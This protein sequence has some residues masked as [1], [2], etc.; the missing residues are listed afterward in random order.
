MIT[1][2]RTTVLATALMATYAMEAR[3]GI[4]IT[5]TDP[6]SGE[7]PEDIE[8]SGDGTSLL[9][10]YFPAN[11]V[12]V[13]DSA[14]LQTSSGF[15]IIA[16]TGITTLENGD[17]L[18]ATAPWFQGVILSGSPDPA[19][20]SAQG[21][22]RIG[23]DGS[24]E[25]VATLPFE[26]VLPNGIAVD[27]RGNTY[28]SNLIGNEIYRIDGT[29]QA[30]VWLRDDILAGNSSQ[31][32]NTPSPGFALGGNG[33]Q[34]VDGRLIASNTDAGTLFS[35]PIDASGNPGVIETLFH[36]DEI[37]GIDGFEMASDGTVYGANLLSSELF[38]VSAAGDVTVLANFSDGIRAPAGV[39]FS[40][41]DSAL[42]FNNAS[43]PF[44]FIAPESAN[45]PGV[46]RLAIVPEPDGK[47]LLLGFVVLGM[48]VTRTR[49]GI[50]AP[51]SSRL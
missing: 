31:D 22:W 33:L 1:T 19:L 6:L 12:A 8:F 39:A 7:I 29:G 35:I 25:Q 15:D 21:V 24:T 45:Q 5:P 20:A 16:P 51:P 46:G 14:T 37:I 30:S 17:S 2:L 28:V 40:D 41:A 50:P 42:F 38:S 26:N 27:A 23:S 10:S 11:R 34:F 44:P 43:F 48:L 47:I 13:F 49:R 3:A 4:V 32:A 36:S 18:V 9:A